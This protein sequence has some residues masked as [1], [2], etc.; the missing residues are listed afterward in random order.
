MS[1]HPHEAFADTLRSGGRTVTVSDHGL[2]PA[3][4]ERYKSPG[5]GGAPLELGRGGLG[6][7]LLVEDRHLGREVALKELLPD[8]KARAG[9]AWPALEARFVREARVMA[10]L[11]HPGVVPVHELV[12]RPDGTL[13]FTMK[14]VSGQTLAKALE[15]CASL[16]DRLTLLPH[17]VDVA[18]TVAFAHARGVVHRDLKPDNVMVGPFGET[19]VLDWG[20]A[21]VPG[22]AEPDAVELPSGQTI[23][24]TTPGLAMGTP[25]F[26]S[27]EQ[28]SGESER[29]DARSD[30]WSLGVM[31]FEL[32]C[33]RPPFEAPTLPALI[34][35]V[36]GQPLPKVKDLEPRAPHA[37]VAIIERALQR[38][39][40]NRFSDAQ[41]FA[42][43][44][45]AA[46]RVPL[47]VVSRSGLVGWVVAGAAVAV[48]LAGWLWPRPPGTG[49]DPAVDRVAYEW[50]A[51]AQE[52]LAQKAQAAFESGD[53]AQAL[54]LAERAT[55]A[56]PPL[57]PGV[58]VLARAAGAPALAFEVKTEAGCAA[59]AVRQGVVACPT[60]GG[61]QLYSE[62]GADLGRLSTQGAGWQRAAVF[63]ADGAL[64]TAGDDRV[65][66]VWNVPSKKQRDAW[67]GAGAEV[68]SLAVSPDGT[69]VV[70]GLVDGRVLEF[71]GAAKPKELARHAGAVRAVA[72]TE[73]TVASAA[74][75]GVQL[76]ARGG[77]P[78]RAVFARGA[79]A[80]WATTNGFLVATERYV[81]SLTENGTATL[82]AT[83]LGQVEALAASTRH[84]VL[85]AGADGRVLAA[86]HA[87]LVP[88][89]EVGAK[90]LAL[91]ADPKS[92]GVDV[93]VALD[94]KR[95]QAW[96]WPLD[97]R[98]AAP[99]ELGFEPTAWAGDL[100][101]GAAAV[102]EREG[103]V[104]W[105]VSARGLGPPLRTRHVGPVT[106]LAKL[107]RRLVSGGADGQ[108]LVH[109][110]G[111]GA[112]QVVAPRGPWAVTALA[113]APTGERVAWALDDGTFGLWS[114]THGAEISKG[115]AARVRA[116]GFSDDGRTVVVGRDDEHV[117]FVD[118]ATGKERSA[119]PG[120]DGVVTAVG[121]HGGLV[122]S[123]AR[124]RKVLVWPLDGTRPS[125]TLVTTSEPS[126]VSVSADGARLAVGHDDGRVLVWRLADG[127]LTHELPTRA[128]RIA[129]VE[130]GANGALFV[131]GTDRLPR[132]LALDAAK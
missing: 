63:L 121:S 108:V 2:T 127:V 80:L 119:Y 9:D 43:A 125:R 131:A 81:F 18:H 31:L 128:G 8:L 76:R 12:R 101:G 105:L 87:P 49:R 115:K 30:V 84:P 40:A 90:V 65:L 35:A 50:R 52:A 122:V 109:P 111:D 41:A 102:G 34:D 67:T 91:G 103:A 13:F 89:L 107:G 85:S 116:L 32:V 117:A 54:A 94:D 36:K 7:V 104:R 6:R 48:G 11:E 71:G 77:G 4:P 1:D 92:P 106:A 79:R 56:G 114:L 23:G 58:A 98:L 62:Q 42:E 28:A 20:L 3:A 120:H 33:G 78:L 19:L 46:E 15:A 74:D 10:R 29:V 97:S 21:K 14:K 82:E 129:A 55:P 59:L 16:N 24:L 68:R 132:W 72:M 124:D 44:L 112:A 70:A 86:H 88:T 5:Q 113:V 66:H 126:A 95:V 53:V 37:L 47:K 57:A 69:V 93:Y 38:E 118:A 99:P 60:F 64:V 61:V 22:E 83:H 100:E 96:R 17:L 75:D 51:R 39:P 27:P 45:V 110:E 26:M 25:R 73:G 123:A 130:L